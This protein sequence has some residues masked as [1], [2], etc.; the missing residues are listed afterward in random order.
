MHGCRHDICISKK[1]VGEVDVFLPRQKSVDAGTI[2]PYSWKVG[3]QTFPI[4]SIRVSP[5]AIGADR[6]RQNI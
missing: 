1:V 4:K 5:I 6:N 3:Y 2:E